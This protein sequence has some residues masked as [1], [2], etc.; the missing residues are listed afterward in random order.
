MLAPGNMKK[1]ILLVDGDAPQLFATGMLLQQFAYNVYTTT[2]TEEALQIVDLALPKAI[3]TE[4]RLPGLSGMDL[5]TTIKKY[6]RTQDVPVVI[7]TG[8]ADRRSEDACLKAGCAAYLKK[9][10]EPDSLY[11]AIQQLTE[12][13]PRSHVRIKT[14][15]TIIVGETGKPDDGEG[16]TVLSENGMYVRTLRPAKVGARLPFTLFLDDRPVRGEGVVLYSYSFG[17][18]PL[19]E[20]GM[21][22]KFLSLSREDKELLRRFIRDHLNA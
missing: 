6:P 11:R 5:L 13:T 20:P 9:P 3:I 15:L 1:I 14:C 17:E 22:V 8:E 18:G 21:G 7:L 16:V 4:L 10:V 2:N 12:P 19:K